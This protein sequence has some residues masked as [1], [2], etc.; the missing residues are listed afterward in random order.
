MP[1]TRRSLLRSALALLG[2]AA[3]APLA[4]ARREATPS[5]P[6]PCRVGWD[7]PSSVLPVE[8]RADTYGQDDTYYPRTFMYETVGPA[9]DLRGDVSVTLSQ[10]GTPHTGDRLVL[11]GVRF[12]W[13][14]GA[15]RRDA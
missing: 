6:P 14:D 13:R 4:W 9:P 8:A 3:L 2:T 5:P 15:W 10:G 11:N 7:D 1:E 12:T